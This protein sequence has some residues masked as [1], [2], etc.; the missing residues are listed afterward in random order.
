LGVGFLG[1]LYGPN[2]NF[3][4]ESSHALPALIRKF[5]L[6]KLAA[7]GDWEA[8]KKDESS[9]G[10]IT[11]DF[12]ACLIS[13]SKNYGHNPQ[14]PT[15]SSLL[16]TPAVVLWG[17]GQP[18]R[19]FLHVDDLADACVFLMNYYNDSEIINIGAGKDIS[20]K[21]LA[22]L[23]KEIVGYN[24][25]IRFDT[26]KPDGTP[27]KLLDVLSIN[28]LGWKP[29]VSL[30]EGIRKTYEWYLGDDQSKKGSLSPFYFSIEMQ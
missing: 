18:R 2:D 5:H 4:L 28:S 6:A 13:I 14:L 21:E 19:E 30:E 8:I 15:A 27:R 24:G 22:L 20:I 29:K 16:L 3:D 17:T 25:E 23:I 26:S 7:L 9:F 11:N 1:I 12:R 10:P